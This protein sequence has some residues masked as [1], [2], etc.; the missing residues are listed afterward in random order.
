M[1]NFGFSINKPRTID[2]DRNN[3]RKSNEILR[4]MPELQ[5]CIGCGT[6]TATCT[7]GNLTDFNFRRCAEASIRVCTR[8]L[9]KVCS[10]A[11]A[12]CCVRAE[13]IRAV[14]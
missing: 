14:L 12:V 10:V 5:T 3:L 6:C 1:I 9:T 7:A 8:S 13:S 11:S 4:E 2:I